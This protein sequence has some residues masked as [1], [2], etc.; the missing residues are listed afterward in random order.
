MAVDG[1]EADGVVQG[2]FEN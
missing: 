2:M 1:E